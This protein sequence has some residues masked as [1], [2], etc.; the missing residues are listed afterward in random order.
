MKKNNNQQNTQVE[1]GSLIASCVCHGFFFIKVIIKYVQ[2][3]EIR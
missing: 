2:E 3:E 1:H